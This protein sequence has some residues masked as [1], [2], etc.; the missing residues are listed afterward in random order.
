MDLKTKRLD[1]ANARVY[2]KPLVQDF[3]KKSQSIAQKIAK[4]TKLDGF[5][6]GKVPLDIIKQRYHGHI[7]QESQKEILD[8]ILKEGAKAL[9]I[10]NQD[11]IG[12]PSV[13][14]FDKQEGYF[15]IEIEIGLRPQIDLSA[16][17]ECVPSFS[18][19]AIQ[20]SAVEE[21]LEILAKQRASFSDAPAEKAVALGDG[22]IFDFEGLLDNQ[23][24]E[25]NRAQNFALIV[26]ENRLLPSFEEQL[27][28]MK[29]GDE[30]YFSVTFP[31]D[32][33]NTNLAGK[34]VS[35]HVKL[36]KIQLR[37]IPEIDDAFIKAVLNQ[38][39]EPTL[40]LLKQRIKDQLFLEAKTKLY[41]QQLKETLID[42]LD[43][44]LSFDLPQTIVEQEMD[45]A[46]NQALEG[47]ST[48]QVKELQED[49]QKLQE[50]RESFRQQARRSVK[51]TF[52]VDALAKQEKIQVGDNEVFQ[53]IYYEAMM[54]N[55]NP[56]QVLEF[57]RKNNMLPAVKM[58]MIEDRVLTFLLDKQLPKES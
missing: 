12:N 56:Q 2:A 24:F 6:R 46:L 44:S 33:A 25:G 17:L 43:E 58:A 3:E 20:E 28:G 9:E 57:Y 50:K 1:S 29:A 51:V 42:K 38:E 54:T 15:D 31:S 48:E 53:T 32:Y 30:K 36:H 41:N 40:E 10:T 13:S 52:I 45:L 27:V 7:Q 26:G 22:V 5:R 4:N 49:S 18:L 8:A 47:M 39:K 21:R 55:Q 37:K 14:K 11:I 19:D 16:V 23:P 35:F 34:E